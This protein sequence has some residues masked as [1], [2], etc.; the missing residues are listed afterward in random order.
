MTLPSP[1]RLAYFLFRDRRARVKRIKAAGYFLTLK[2][3]EMSVD[4]LLPCLFFRD[5]TQLSLVTRD[6]LTVSVVSHAQ[7]RLAIHAVKKAANKRYVSG[8]VK[9]VGISA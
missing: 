1:L 3:K 7:S 2:R 8:C 9:K 5:T 6:C 4:R